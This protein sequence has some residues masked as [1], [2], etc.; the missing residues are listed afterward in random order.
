MEREGYAG[1]DIL[2]ALCSEEEGASVQLAVGIIT[3]SRLDPVLRVIDSM[4]CNLD[5]GTYQSVWVLSD[6]GSPSGYIEAVQRNFPN[7]FAQIIVLPRLGMGANWNACVKA[8]QHHADVT[9]MNQDDWLFTCPVPAGFYADFLHANPRYGLVRLHTLQQQ[10]T[11]PC[12]PHR[13]VRAADERVLDYFEVRPP[14][15]PTGESPYSGGVHLRHRRFTETYGDYPV[16]QSLADT[17]NMFMHRVSEKRHAPEALNFAV[18]M[19]FALS[20]F[21]TIAPSFRNTAV[22]FETLAK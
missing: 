1:C 11:L 21:T 15:P 10:F 14:D 9:L 6:D 8:C 5:F 13:W 22:E 12:Y 19:D 18:P 7:L 4:L 17:E 16:G 20:R 2:T 3:Y